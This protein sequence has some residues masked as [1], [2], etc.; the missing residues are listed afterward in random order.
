MNFLI[1][2]IIAILPSRILGRYIYKKDPERKPKKILIKIILLSIVFTIVA[3]MLE[4][5]FRKAYPTSETFFEYLIEYMIGIA[6]VEEMCKFLPAYWIGIRKNMNHKYDAIVYTAFSAIGLATFENILYVLGSENSIGIAVYRMIFAVPGHITDGILMGY[7]LGIAY[8]AKQNGNKG[9][10]HLNK[11]YSLLIP[12]IFHGIFDFSIIYGVKSMSIFVLGVPFILS[13]IL[14]IYA[15]RKIKKVAKGQEE[16][17]KKKHSGR[18]L[19][20]LG[21][22]LIASLWWVSNLQIGRLYNMHYTNEVVKVKEDK[23]SITLKSF[24]KE[25]ISNTITLN[26]EIKNLSNETI[27]LG[28]GQFY[29]TNMNNTKDTNVL[30]R[31]EINGQNLLTIQP[32]SVVK[33]KVSFSVKSEIK[34]NNYLFVYIPKNDTAKTYPIFLGTDIVQVLKNQ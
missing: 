20:I 31:F 14:F 29:L 28:A 7:F 2:M 24:K 30:N 33:T 9:Q 4:W 26:M 17:G 27:T 32:N 21:C 34:D 18:N 8:E 13:I 25:E 19:F 16:V 11:I 22:I 23:V 1:S 12:I 3:V 5:G 15:I 6:L 10:Y